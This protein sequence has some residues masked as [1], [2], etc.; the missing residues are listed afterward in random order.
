MRRISQSVV[1]CGENERFFSFIVG[2]NRFCRGTVAF[3]GFYVFTS[4]VHIQL[5]PVLTMFG[6]SKSEKIKI[7]IGF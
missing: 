6:K 4:D 3:G 7:K 5:G 1:T 2:N